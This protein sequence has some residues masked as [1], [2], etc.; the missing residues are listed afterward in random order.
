MDGKWLYRHLE[1]KQPCRSRCPHCRKGRDPTVDILAWHK[2]HL[3]SVKSLPRLS[4][5]GDTLF[6]S[7]SENDSS[8]PACRHWAS[9][10]N[11]PWR[12]LPTAA[13][14]LAAEVSPPKNLHPASEWD[15]M[16]SHHEPASI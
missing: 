15:E 8:I 2:P 6:T 4:R 16:S 1:P 10:R 14:G 7:L 3:V 12:K 9:R 11:R 13:S 5:V